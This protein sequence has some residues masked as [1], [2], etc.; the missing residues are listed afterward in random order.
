ME[1]ESDLAVAS[2]LAAATS[3][4]E[5]F[6][7]EMSEGDSEF[8]SLASVAVIFPVSV[9]FDTTPVVEE[10][11]PT[12]RLETSAVQSSGNPP[13]LQHVATSQAKQSAVLNKSTVSSPLQMVEHLSSKSSALHSINALASHASIKT[14]SVHWLKS[15]P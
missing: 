5:L 13:S 8:T 2:V 3:S 15:P 1:V 7:V 6:E 12:R 11:R 9:P 10:S 4:V 14:V